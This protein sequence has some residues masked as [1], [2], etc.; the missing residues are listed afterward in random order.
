M[1]HDLPA[2]TQLLIDLAKLFVKLG[3]TAFGAGRRTLPLK[4]CLVLGR[5]VAGSTR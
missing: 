5:F 3:I 2:K 4:G 1:S